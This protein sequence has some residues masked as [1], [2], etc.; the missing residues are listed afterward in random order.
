MPINGQTVFFGVAL[1][2]VS[3]NPNLVTSIFGTLSEDLVLPLACGD[4]C[5]DAF[6]VQTGL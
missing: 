2:E 1:C 6:H 4:F 3:G 5:V